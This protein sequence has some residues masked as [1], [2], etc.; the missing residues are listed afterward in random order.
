[1]S[2]P[3]TPPR[4]RPGLLLLV[5]AVGVGL[6]VTTAALSLRRTADPSWE[7]VHADFAELN[8]ALER[9]RAARGTL[10]DEGT[11]DFL[12]PE[13][14]P[15]VPVDPWGRPYIYSHNGKQVMLITYGRDGERGGTGPEQD[16]TPHDGHGR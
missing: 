8:D 9:Y 16:H 13:F 4:L 6:A 14:L 7:R 2:A 11:L 12:V 5:M 15:E 1:M 3:A 10:P